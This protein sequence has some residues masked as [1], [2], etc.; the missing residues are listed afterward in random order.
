MKNKNSDNDD[1]DND[2]NDE[3]TT[4]FDTNL[5]LVIH[6]ITTTLQHMNIT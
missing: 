3:W 4:Y 1:D 6:T 2:D 5:P